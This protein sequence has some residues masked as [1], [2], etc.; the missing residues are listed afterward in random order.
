M[1][2]SQNC[3]KKGTVS[4]FLLLILAAFFLSIGAVAE[5]SA[6]RAARS[7]GD[8]AFRLAGQSLLSEYSRELKENY[9]LFALTNDENGMEKRAWEY[10]TAFTQKSRGTVDVLQTE[11]QSL[12]LD[13]SP[14]SLTNPNLLEEQIAAC[15]KYRS[16]E[17]LKK[18]LSEAPGEDEPK[19]FPKE[20]KDEDQRV[21]RNKEII[22][23]LPS[24]AF[25]IRGISLP[26][27]SELPNLGE[28][29]ENGKDALF[30]NLYIA[31]FFSNRNSRNFE[32][33]TFFR[34]EMEY[35]LCGKLSDKENEAAAKALLITLRTG[36]DLAH[37]Y[38]SPEKRAEVQAM[39]A[40]LTPGPES[41]AT[42]AVLA[43]TWAAGEAAND[44]ARL[45]KG[46]CVPLVKTDEDWMLCLDA[47]LENLFE[48]KVLEPETSEGLN[49][50]GYL[51][52]LLFFED[53]E[54]KLVRIM[55]LI[56]INMK[57]N[58]DSGFSMAGSYAGFQLN[59]EM[60]RIKSFFNLTG[61][62]TGEFH[63]IFLYDRP[64]FTS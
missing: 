34:S 54:A 22:E 7:C 37:I 9:G 56:Q 21:L 20:E 63:M 33:E 48:G 17:L 8:A 57:G 62:R 38:S 12:S 64:E 32:K 15:M 4:V 24:R 31:S 26:D 16:S 44:V 19:T 61:K 13:F 18:V 27:L 51:I 1:K 36:V 49:Y 46:G 30:L 39:A 58:Y 28:L 40:V 2:R 23:A 60:A 52:L 10:L 14:Y 43:L 29:L 50:K 59:G 47:V 35:I 11:L 55:D 25:Q 42:Q 53:R 41:V 45:E 5:V 6:G 3:G